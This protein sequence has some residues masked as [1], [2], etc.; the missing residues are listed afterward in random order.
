MDL[1]NRSLRGVVSPSL[2]SLRRLAAR[3]SQNDLHG[4]APAGLTAL[5]LSWNN[6]RGTARASPFS[7]FAGPH[8]AFPDAANLMVL[9]VSGNNF[10]DVNVTDLCC[11]APV[12]ILRLRKRVLRQGPRRRGAR[13][14]LSRRQW[15]HREPS[16]RPVRDAVAAETEL[17]GEQPLW[18]HR[19]PR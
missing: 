17:A 7:K 5:N 19:Q 10:S 3:L 16:G 13:R 1:S 2:A 14:A 11:A 9:G 8:P 4:T 6:L 12:R 18:Y 15:P